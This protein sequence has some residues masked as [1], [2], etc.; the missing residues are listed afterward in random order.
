MSKFLLI[1]AIGLASLSFS[2]CELIPED[3]EL[4]DIVG[5]DLPEAPSTQ[6]CCRHLEW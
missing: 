3:D 1:L 6:R 2:G 4:A 5:I